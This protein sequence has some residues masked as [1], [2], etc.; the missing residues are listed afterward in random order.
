[1]ANTR[2]DKI[3]LGVVRSSFSIRNS[4]SK[5]SLQ[6]RITLLQKTRTFKAIRSMLRSIHAAR[7]LEVRRKF[8]LLVL[9]RERTVMMTAS[10]WC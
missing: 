5:N 7:M 8:T 3:N 9:C 2:P 1:M 6:K 4:H 10:Q